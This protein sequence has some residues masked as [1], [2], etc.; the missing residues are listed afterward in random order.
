[1][2]RERPEMVPTERAA[3]VPHRSAREAI[4]VGMGEVR[5]TRR[6]TDI[7]VAHGLGSCI[8]LCVRDPAARV[9]GMA[10]IVLPQR[11]ERGG[12]TVGPVLGAK[13]ADEGVPF[14]MEAMEREGAAVNRLKIALVG[15]A[16]LFATVGGARLD[17]G[18]RNILV[19][20]QALKERGVGIDAHDL[21]GNWGRTCQLWASDGRIVVRTIGACERELAVL[22]TKSTATGKNE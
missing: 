17:I 4:T 20:L 16:Q 6:A 8:A 14:L 15:A 2:Q 21:G 22:G 18:N 5:V 9:A 7:L 13:F 11:P 1:M 3:V 12:D 19:V 10:H